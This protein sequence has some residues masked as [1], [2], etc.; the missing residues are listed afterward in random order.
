MTFFVVPA[1]AVACTG[2]AVGCAPPVGT[3]THAPAPITLATTVD[4]AGVNELIAGSSRFST[5][6]LDQLQLHLLDEQTDWS[7]GPPSMAAGLADSWTVAPDRRSVTMRLR[8][9]ARWSDGRPVTAD[10]VLFTFA[11]QTSPAVAWVYSNSKQLVAGVD[12]LDARTVRFRLQS[13]CPAPLVEIN[14]GRILPAHAWRELPFERWHASPGWFRERSVASGPFQLASWRP[15]V[16][17]TLEANP[18]F[19]DPDP[20]GPRRIVVRVVPDPAAAVERLRAGEF[21]FFD[22]LSPRQA[23]RLRDVPRLRIVATET[24]QF[25]YIGWNLRRPPFDDPAV[26]RALT[27]GIDREELVSTLWR[28]WA[29]VATGPV[30]AGAWA[31]DTELAPW[32]Y[33]P[34]AAAALLTERGWIDRDGDGVRERDGQ[35]FRF[36]LLTNTGNRIRIDAATL[37]CERLR[38]LGIDATPRAVEMQLL[39]DL[40]LAGQFDATLA[41]W[42]IDTTFDLRPWFHSS[43]IEGGWNFVAYRDAEVDRLLAA[44]RATSDLAIARRHLVAAQRRLHDDQPYT[45]LWEP[46]RLTAVAADLEGVE[47]RPLGALRNLHRWRRR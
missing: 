2:L 18:Y 34:A 25:D 41:G 30:P 4:L 45:F 11:A 6:I 1:C 29:R 33:D 42:S 17:F 21:D 31:H 46:R 37:I 38:R 8:A 36:V 44:A 13:D 26:R 20:H 24:G 39:T 7:V 19:H 3:T 10:D 23:E 15:G 12:A 9:D 27:M 47:I 14:D 22:G 40:N 16:D 28:G 32:P 43:E 5:E 35:P